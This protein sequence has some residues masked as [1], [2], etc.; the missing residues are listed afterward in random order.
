VND[1][2]RTP[3]GCGC[4]VGRQLYVV[5]IRP[6]T[7]EPPYTVGADLKRQN[8]KLHNHKLSDRQKKNRKQQKTL[9]TI[10]NNNNDH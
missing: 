5:L 8:K 6:L 1:V 9:D 2:V 10:I 4:G 7:W 3:H